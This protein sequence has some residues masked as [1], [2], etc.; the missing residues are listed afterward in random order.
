MDK[1]MAENLQK[2]I[3][4][5]N[6][7][8]ESINAKGGTIDDSTPFSEYAGQVDGFEVKEKEYDTMEV[9]ITQATTPN[10]NLVSCTG[11]DEEITIDWG[12]GE[13][14]TYTITTSGTVCAKPTPYAVGE[15][16]IKLPATEN[17][18]ISGWGTKF[19]YCNYKKVSFKYFRVLSSSSVKSIF[20]SQYKLTDVNLG[21]VSVNIG[22]V[23]IGKSLFRQCVSLT[24][25]SIPNGINIIGE[26]S[27]LSF[28]N[29]S[30]LTKITIPS[31][32]TKINTSA[33]RIGS[34]NTKAIITFLSETPCI[35]SSPF[36]INTLKYILVPDK[37]IEAYK[38]ATN[39]SVYADYI[40]GIN[41]YKFLD[42]TQFLIN[43]TDST[44][45]ET[46]IEVSGFIGDGIID[47][48]DGTIE[49]FGSSSTSASV[50]ITKNYSLIG[51]Y[52]IKV[53]V[54][55]YS[56]QKNSGVRYINGN[57]AEY[58]E[59]I[60]QWQSNFFKVIP[61]NMLPYSNITTL[62]IPEG[63]T[64]VQTGVRNCPNLINLNLPNSLTNV[65]ISGCPNLTTLT[66]PKNVTRINY[67][68]IGSA[69]NKATITFESETPCTISTST[70]KTTDLQ[71]IRVPM[72]AVDTYKSATNWSV[73]ADYIVGYVPEDEITI[74]E[75]GT[76]DVS[77]KNTAIVNVSSGSEENIDAN[78]EV[79]E[80]ELIGDSVVPGDF[81]T[82]YN[83]YSKLNSTS[84]SCYNHLSCVKL[85][86]T[87]LFIAHAYGS[88]Y[89]LYCTIAAL[90]SS[91]SIISYT[92]HSLNTTEKICYTGLSCTLIDENK[93]LITHGD[94]DN[95]YLYGTIVVVDGTT[96]SSNTTT[97]IQDYE[98]VCSSRPYCITLDTN[99][100][101]VAY[102]ESDTYARVC[103][104]SINSTSISKGE[105]S[106]IN[107]S[108]NG[109]GK[110][111]YEIVDLIKLSS[112][113]A[114]V[115]HYGKMLND[116][117]T[118]LLCSI[119]S[120]SGTNT[121]CYQASVISNNVYSTLYTA[122]CTLLSD[123]KVVVFNEQS[124]RYYATVLTV[125]TTTVSQVDYLIPTNW[126]SAAINFESCVLMN[127]DKIFVITIID[128]IPI[129]FIIEF[130]E[131]NISCTSCYLLNKINGKQI[132]NI[133]CVKLD[134]NKI[135]LVHD[136]GN[137][138]CYTTYDGIKVK[139][140]FRSTSNANT[141]NTN[142]VFS[143]I[144][145][146]AKTGGDAS[147]IIE[148]YA[149]PN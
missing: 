137:Y 85:N 24:N 102:R 129:Y 9:E 114:L 84:G 71:E 82:Y 4:I 12:D 37:S 134:E 101:L 60:L 77:E 47:W 83:T 111:C 141:T 74:T 88:N 2:F 127:S 68:Y 63:V 44:K 75:N 90:S 45:L 29:C 5:K 110:P 54:E 116:S 108:S 130:I 49:T 42:S 53:L 147:D 121:H 57:H 140:Y 81:I 14:T 78:A 126:R 109:A 123:N 43:L 55:N 125:G 16:T 113:K 58:L 99:K 72:S 23:D 131:D 122:C 100:A 112:T 33:L 89:K 87:T 21:E 1:T 79:R 18:K 95:K 142:D 117:P 10:Y 35:V 48:G 96:I 32:V 73:Y 94:Y 144:I 64:D 25:I 27:G 98:G 8:K 13:V 124:N 104:L 128:G 148:V 120:V 146:I 138:L 139:K 61:Y 93:I 46:K 70:F 26:T 103:V 97:I 107:V 38:S 145:G 115:V 41:E 7:L 36:D 69:T 86:D 52:T 34:I 20:D 135:L 40:I 22:L 62:T 66:I 39:W 105:N 59:E 92:T 50:D 133:E 132:D 80:F 31:S 11:A 143:E 6:D 67:V 56:V 119:V 30:S 65:D 17:Y 19:N 51:T 118:Q 149:I 136:L 76:Y 15:Y 106:S 3:D 28:Y 91:N